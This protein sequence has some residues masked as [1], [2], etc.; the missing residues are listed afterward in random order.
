MRAK[1]RIESMVEADIGAVVDMDSPTYFRESQLRDELRRPWSHMWVARE[2]GSASSNLVGF[3]A[4]WHVVDELHVLNLVTRTDRRRTGI[5]RG[6]MEA[7]LAFAR[8]KRVKQVLLEVRR[9]NAAAIALYRKVGF[10]ATRVRAAYYADDEDA[11]E[12]TLRLDP[13]TGEVVLREDEAG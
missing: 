10:H 6:L 1:V 2:A 12:M 8:D 11:V 9:S 13:N 5:G 4:L 3:L 7:A